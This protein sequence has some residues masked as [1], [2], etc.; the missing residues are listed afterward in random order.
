MEPIGRG[1]GAAA[2]AAVAGGEPGAVD[3]LRL[4]AAQRMGTDARRSVFCV[5]M[6][7]EDHVDAFERLMRLPLKVSCA[8]STSCEQC[9]LSHSIFAVRCGFRV[10]VGG[11]GAA[12]RV[13]GTSVPAC[14]SYPLI[15]IPHALRADHGPT[16][17]RWDSQGAVGILRTRL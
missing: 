15:P 14:C 4:A 5:V 8:S 10:C 16:C 7:A 11:G 6:G 17:T 9:K 1:G 12:S 2:A 13:G 3:L